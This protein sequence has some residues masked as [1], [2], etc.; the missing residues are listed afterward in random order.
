M[1]VTKLVKQLGS[2]PPSSVVLIA[3]RGRGKSAALG[4]ALR[5][6]PGPSRRVAITAGSREATIEVLRFAELPPEAF[7]STQELLYGDSTWDLIVIDE[8][9]QIP[10]PVLQRIVER[11]PTASFAFATT[12]HGYEGTGRGFALRFLA[13]LRSRTKPLALLTLSDPIRWGAGDPLE[14]L[15]FNLLLLHAES[16]E[17]IPPN[18]ACVECIHR[19]LNRDELVSNEPLLRSFF[20]LLVHAHYRTTPGDLHRLLDAPNIRAHALTRGNHVLAATLVAFEGSLEEKTCDDLY[21]GRYRVRGQAFPETL[22][23]HSGERTAGTLSIIRS[24]R[25]AVHPSM[26]RCGLATRLVGCVHDTYKPDFFGTLFGLSPGLLQFRRSAGY[27]LVRVGSSRGTRTGEPAVVMIRPVTARAHN[28]HGRLR[29][30]LARQITA[31]I[32]LMQAG[33]EILLSG[34]LIAD[35]RAGLPAPI[36]PLSPDERLEAVRVYADGPRTMEATCIALHE[37]VSE[38]LEALAHLAPDAKALIEARIL[39]RLGWEEAAVAAN[40]PSAVAAMRA[41][42]RAVRA[43]VRHLGPEAE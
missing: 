14:A 30:K 6:L 20:G 11:H 21:W 39:N 13:W 38:N 34:S 8:A 5:D 4:L 36:Q 40:L 43:L 22:A 24:V 42:R 37:Y 15:I 31:Q 1:M 29:M 9:A 3:D 19:V 18:V 7:I 17:E 25:I 10:V 12:T 33:N 41:L 16:P 26:R 35:L 28:L 2:S 23:S 27:E 32:Q